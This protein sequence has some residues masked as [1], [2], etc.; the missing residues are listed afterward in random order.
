MAE[1]AQAGPEEAQRRERQ[2]RR[3]RSPRRRLRS[4]VAA[5]AA[6]VPLRR[7]LRGLAGP[8]LPGAMEGR[9]ARG[10][11]T[12]VAPSPAASG[13]SSQVQAPPTE[14]GRGKPRAANRTLTSEVPVNKTA[15]L[16][17]ALCPSAP[18]WLAQIPSEKLF[19]LCDV[20]LDVC[21]LSRFSAWLGQKEQPRALQQAVTQRPVQ[22]MSG[23]GEVSPKSSHQSHEEKRRTSL[24]T[25]EK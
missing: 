18:L 12:R 9:Q 3:H 23:A 1:G 24:F 21:L 11:E 16:A 6:A 15:P 19:R 5:A 14:K 22:G 13:F 25:W 7:R 4:A 2:R 17:R 20:L 10:A 8:P